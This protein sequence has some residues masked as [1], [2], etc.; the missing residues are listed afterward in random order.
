[1]AIIQGT[2]SYGLLESVG[3]KAKVVRGCGQGVLVGFVARKKSKGNRESA[4]R[5]HS[6]SQRLQNNC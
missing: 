4:E 5:I 6:L 3:S 1:M 2:L